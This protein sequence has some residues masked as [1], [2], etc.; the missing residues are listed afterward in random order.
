MIVFIPLLLFIRDPEGRSGVGARGV[1]RGRVVTRA[2]DVAWRLSASCCNSEQAQSKERGRD[3]L[4]SLVQFR[5]SA[6]PN[7]A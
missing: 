6:A 7:V 5:N 2:V 1:A 4:Q 3:A